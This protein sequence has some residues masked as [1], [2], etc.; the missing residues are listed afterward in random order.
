MYCWV[1]HNQASYTQYE[2]TG[3]SYVVYRRLSLCDEIEF[4]TIFT[5]KPV[6]ETG[7][8]LLKED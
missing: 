6:L 4:E 1:D 8:S 3:P 7:A 5:K 2:S